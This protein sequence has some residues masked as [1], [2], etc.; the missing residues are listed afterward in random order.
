MQ[1]GMPST[2]EAKLVFMH[3]SSRFSNMLTI[4]RHQLLEQCSKQRTAVA[5]AGHCL[6]LLF[7]VL[8][9]HARV[10]TC[11]RRAVTL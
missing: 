8:C 11:R 10:L 3:L 9:A 5:A 2:Y 6:R 7:R 4:L 1:L